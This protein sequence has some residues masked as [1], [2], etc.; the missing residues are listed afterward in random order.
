[1]LQR[2]ISAGQIS[3]LPLVLASLLLPASAGAQVERTHRD[4]WQK[5]EEIFA[6]M[7]LDEGDRVADV[8]AGGGFFTFRLSPI[9]GPQGKVFAQDIDGGVLREVREAAQRE[10]MDN[11]ETVLGVRDDP[12]LP[13][14]SLDAVLIVNAYHEMDEYEGMLAGI[15]R[16][17]KPGGRLVIVDDPPRDPTQP[18]RQQMQQHDI[19]IGLVEQDLETAGFEVIRRE[20]DFVNDDHGRHHHRSWMLVAV[21]RQSR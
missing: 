21:P 15:R 5:V 16:A 14:T 4:E 13:P 3:V 9:V 8:G 6:A 1:M 11:I 20:P 10:A 12:R 7:D 19:D 17:L 2:R 18:R